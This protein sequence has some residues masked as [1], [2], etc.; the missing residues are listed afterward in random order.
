MTPKDIFAFFIY[1]LFIFSFTFSSASNAETSKEEEVVAVV[2]AKKI[3]LEEFNKKYSEV[4]SQSI[5]PPSKQLFLEDLVRYEVG[6]QEASK[7]KLENDPVVKEHFNQE[8]YKALVEKEIG[9][10]VQDIKVSE[11][12]MAEWYKK[13]P[14]IRT[15][16][17]LIEFKQGAT[18]KEK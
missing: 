8:L 13:N 12:E 4:K 7:R 6:L 15:S 10:K 3:T 9:A 2:G 18:E 1:S 14:E 5:N 16:H 11:T 17:I